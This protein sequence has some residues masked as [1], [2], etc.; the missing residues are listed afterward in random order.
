M[1]RVITQSTSEPRGD[2]GDEVDPVIT[3][4]IP[5]PRG[6]HEEEEN[7]EA[8]SQVESEIVNEEMDQDAGE[9]EDVVLEGSDER[10][11]NQKREM[12]GAG[13]KHGSKKR[14]QDHKTLKRKKEGDESNRERKR[15]RE[16]EENNY[17]NMEVE[18]I[19][20]AQAVTEEAEKFGLP[21]GM[22]FDITTGW[23]FRSPEHQELA[24][25]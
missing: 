11:K 15:G 23:D 13:E 9:E 8:E 19:H 3:Q 7:D 14:R 17:Q 25:T 6:D 5:E 16:K 20:R 1:D 2:H 21:A 10:V 12:G 22:V 4:S 18:E 24:K